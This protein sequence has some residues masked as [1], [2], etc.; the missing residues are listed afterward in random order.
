MP[1]IE[2]LSIPIFASQGLRSAQERIV[3][4]G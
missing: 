2:G 4:L 1:I 3:T